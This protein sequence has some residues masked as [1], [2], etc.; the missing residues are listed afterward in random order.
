MDEFIARTLSGTC[1]LYFMLSN[2]MK[3]FPNYFS[4]RMNVYIV[5]KGAGGIWMDRYGIRSSEWG[6]GDLT[7]GK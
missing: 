1:E 3:I 7:E 6:S 4:I 2:E 5:L